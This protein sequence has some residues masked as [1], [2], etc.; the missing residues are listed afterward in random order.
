MFCENKNR[1]E[2]TWDDVDFFEQPFFYSSMGDEAISNTA[3]WIFFPALWPFLHSASKIHQVLFIMD[4]N[5]LL[6]SLFPWSS[7]GPTFSK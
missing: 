5:D 3:F 4:H 6:F 1:R 2:K 7:P